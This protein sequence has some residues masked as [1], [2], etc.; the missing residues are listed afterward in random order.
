MSVGEV[1]DALALRSGLIEELS[2]WAPTLVRLLATALLGV[3]LALVG[4]WLVRTLVRRTGLDALAERLGVVRLLYSVQIKTG[5]DRVLGDLTGLTILLATA[6][7]M[8]E[9]V[10]LPGIA[11]G[12][13]AIL[14]FLPRFVT[15]MMLCLAGF[16]AADVTS[17]VVGTVLG[18][19]SDLVS[20]AL[21]QNVAYYT[22]VAVFVT[23]AV[24]HL[25]LDTDLVDGLILLVAGIGLSSLGL[26]FALGSRSVV[27]QL[28]VRQYAPFVARPGDQVRIGEV[29]GTLLRYDA[30]TLV[31]KDDEGRKHVLP[32]D[33]LLREQGIVV[34]SLSAG[35]S[36]DSE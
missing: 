34:S 15:A 29:S 3:L 7:L 35:A 27:R 22:I 12:F 24:Q 30:I 31:V 13:S 6:V 25:G 33:V 20:P 1:V 14:E 32:C 26:S 19:R 17:R 10:S 21:A 5:V 28:L 18:S 2:A 16:L 9:S 8:A 36:P 11:E 23:T 4:R